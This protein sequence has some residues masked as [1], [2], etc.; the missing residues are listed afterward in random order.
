VPIISQVG[1]KSWGVRFLIC[2]IYTILITGSITTVYPFLVMVNGSLSGGIDI[3]EFPILP[4]YLYNDVEL[5]RRYLYVK[6][7]RE[8]LFLRR[9]HHVDYRLDE[10]GEIKH[11]RRGIATNDFKEA[12]PPKDEVSDP[13]VRQRVTDYEE[14]MQAIE[15]PF[16][17]AGFFWGRG[18][19]QEE[20]NFINNP[21]I[22]RR[23]NHDIEAYNRRHG[24]YMKAFINISIPFAGRMRWYA[25]DCRFPLEE[26]FFE[27]LE[28]QDFDWLHPRLMTPS[29]SHIYY[30]R[31]LEKKYRDIESLNEAYGTRYETFLTVFMPPR[32]PE[33]EPERSDWGSFM[34]DKQM[35]LPFFFIR[36]DVVP[37]TENLFREFV[38]TRYRS[39]DELNREYAKR[40]LIGPDQ[41]SDPSQLGA[42]T[43]DVYQ[44]HVT[45]LK[46]LE[47]PGFLDI[48]RSDYTSFDEV[49]LSPVLPDPD[50]LPR[51][52][53]WR[54]FVEEAVPFEYLEARTASTEYRKFLEGKYGTIGALNEAYATNYD[55]FRNVREP[56]SE[57]DWMDFQSRKKWYRKYFFY[58]NFKQVFEH[59]K[60]SDIPI[61]WNTVYLCS[62]MVLLSLTI[63]PLAA[64][65]LS[66]FN[67]SYTYKVLLFCLATMAFPA[68]VTMIPNFLL[69][70][71]LGLLNTYWALFLPAAASGFSIFLLKGFFDSLPPELYECAVL[72]GC[73]ELG[74]FWRITVP[75]S[76]PIF[77]VIALGSF[78]GAYGSFM[79]ALVVCQNP[80]KW[81]LMVWLYEF[82]QIWAPDAVMAALVMA[83][84]PT[85]VVFILCQ[86]V[87][88]R[89]I[90]VPSFK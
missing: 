70:K 4:K 88:M 44:K 55:S 18:T 2:S 57:R 36:V 45:R 19:R 50:Y 59:L 67:L 39:I 61:V 53:D 32:A 60:L 27:V 3:D 66:R 77:A 46:R 82:Q 37:E 68:E 29:Q 30:W 20:M 14:F 48:P 74:M 13:R 52:E 25:R 80:R 72:E 17:R 15:V 76:R 22:A 34:K 86:K 41:L 28:I 58:R 69:L 90:I 54:T 5:Y 23:Y 78:M 38:R 75:L 64:F 56:N 81:T 84:I 73:S 24:E 62:M 10:K 65:A 9:W 40:S 79:W 7:A 87:I 71:K 31:Y 83:A 1:R 6:Y 35:G 49:D 26:H 33:Q 12:L 16:Y 63:N 51:G 47:F 21:W 89:G 85:L 8:P 11:R 42:I 43:P